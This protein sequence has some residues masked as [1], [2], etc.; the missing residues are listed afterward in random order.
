MAAPETRVIAEV[1]SYYGAVMGQ[2]RAE[3]L[4]AGFPH[5]SI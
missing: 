1:L 4:L 2:V 5:S 3:V